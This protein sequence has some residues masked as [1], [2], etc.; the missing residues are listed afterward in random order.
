MSHKLRRPAFLPGLDVCTIPNLRAELLS[1]ADPVDERDKVFLL[2]AG[3]P[4][5]PRPHTHTHTHTT[6]THTP[7]THT[8]RESSAN[9]SCRNCSRMKHRAGGRHG[10]V[11]G[12]PKHGQNTCPGWLTPGTGIRTPPGGGRKKWSQAD[13]V[14]PHAE[15]KLW[16]GRLCS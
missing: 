6:H 11:P 13:E 8:H 7:H 2:P 4:R 10:Q 14:P 15:R 1:P 9:H 3:S 5:Q 16:N 12:P